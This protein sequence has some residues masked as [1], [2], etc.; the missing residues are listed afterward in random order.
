MALKDYLLVFITVILW[1]LNAVFVRFGLGQIPPFLITAMRLLLITVF[2]FPFIPKPPKAM[3]KHLITI[4][5]LLGI[6]HFGLLNFSLLGIDSGT[7]AT[8][9]QLGVPF[10]ALLA[11]F[12]LKEQPS[13]A[14]ILGTFGAFI[15]VYILA[16][17][18]SGIGNPVYFIAAVLSAFAW[19]CA[20]I[21][22]KKLKDVSAL[23]IGFYIGF[24][25]WPL[26]FLFS[27]LS[28]EGN[29]ISIMAASNWKGWASVLYSTIGSNIIANTLWY[30]LLSKN[31]INNIV[32][33]S[34]LTPVS[35]FIGGLIIMNEPILFYKVI[36]AVIVI[37]SIGLSEYVKNYK[38][39]KLLRKRV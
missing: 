11:T 4:S 26:M 32:F 19:A 1:G 18:A 12:L 3:R 28:G 13:L 9:I 36:G 23:Q 33:F 20:N 31:N 22:I 16:G 2:L 14:T 17:G 5:L 38:Y 35:S 7:G 27:Y 8:L 10:S 34:F 6:G 37:G 30:K 15:G 29:P 21:V 25:S 24:Y 39:R